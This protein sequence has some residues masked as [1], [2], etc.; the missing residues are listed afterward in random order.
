MQ[1]KP[2]TVLEEILDIAKWAPSGDNAQPWQFEIIDESHFCIYSQDTRHRCIYDLQGRASQLALGMLLENIVISAS[3]Y[4]KTV[5]I[6]SLEKNLLDQGNQLIKI[7]I[8]VHQATNA[9]VNPLFEFIK[10]RA[11]NRKPYQLKAI[12]PRHFEHLEQSLPEGYRLIWFKTLKQRL[13]VAKIVFAAQGIALTTPEAFQ[14]H[15]DA[16]EWDKQFSEDR[17]PS[18]AIGASKPTLT[19][20]KWAMQSWQRINFLNTYLL[21]TLMPRIELNLLPAIF[22]SAHFLIFAPKKNDTAEEQI[23]SGRAVQKFWLTVTKLG[24]QLQPQ[25]STLIL[26]QYARNNIT[27]SKT[28]R[29]IA[30]AKTLSENFT[31]VISNTELDQ[32]VFFGRIGY[33]TF[34]TARSLRKEL[35]LLLNSSS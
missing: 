28:A 32:A 2:Q 13:A 25:M 15:V 5:E 19:L 10:I 23:E 21:G 35:K 8:K 22:S 7:T 9:P 3:R 14:T 31:A 30:L 24:L 18:L 11:T 4:K 17:I 29:Q 27:F 33:S 20:M 1:N 26:S 16:I 12:N 6:I 34:P